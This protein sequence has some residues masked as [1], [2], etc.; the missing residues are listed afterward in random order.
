M[1]LVPITAA[2][3]VGFLA[4]LLSFKIKTRWCRT[5]G[6][7]LTCP[8]PTYHVDVPADRRSGHGAPAA[9]LRHLI[10]TL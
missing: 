8:D 5:C 6:A 4:R 2:I 10:R 1:L 3:V 9:R 7:I